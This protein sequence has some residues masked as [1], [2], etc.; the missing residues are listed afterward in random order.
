MHRIRLHR[1]VVAVAVILGMLLQG[2]WVLAGTTGQITGTLNDSSSRKAIF[3]A[4]VSAI[5]PSQAASVTTDSQGRFTFLSLAPDT[6]SISV[7]VTGYQS[8]TLN[9]ITVQA[10]QTQTLALTAAPSLQTIGRTQSRA[11][12]DVIKAGQT[13]DVYS[14]SSAQAS[15]ASA[16][17]GGGSLN[18]A[19]SAIASVPGVFV[20]IGQQGWAQS[21]YVRG[22]N[23]TLFTPTAAKVFTNSSVKSGSWSWI[24]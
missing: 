15:A 7:D 2:T 3:G 18:Q 23:L 14:I 17:G 1:F 12:S 4:K 6:Y 16:L 11:A 24:K 9:G 22:G 13:A 19:Y 10:D 21:V 8:S 5:S 20:P